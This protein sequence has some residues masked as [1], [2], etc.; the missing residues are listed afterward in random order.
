[1]EKDQYLFNAELSINSLRSGVVPSN[2]ITDLTLGQTKISQEIERRLRFLER[3]ELKSFFVL[4]SYGEGKTHTLEFMKDRV[5][6]NNAANSLLTLHPKEMKLSHQPEIYGTIVSSL[7]LPMSTSSDGLYTLL[8][9]WEKKF[10]KIGA[11]NWKEYVTSLFADCNNQR[12]ILD[13]AVYPL[14]KDPSE[15]EF[16]YRDLLGEK[17]DANRLK[18]I[19]RSTIFNSSIPKSLVVD[20]EEYLHVIKIITRVLLEVG[21]KGL[22][23]LFDEV[24]SIHDLMKNQRKKVYENMVRFIRISPEHFGKVLVI[25]AVTPSFFHSI[26]K[27]YSVSTFEIRETIL[28]LDQ[29][30]LTFTSSADELIS[31]LKNIMDAHGVTYYWDPES[32]LSQNH[33]HRFAKKRLGEELRSVIRYFIEILDY[34]YLYSEDRLL[35]DIWIEE[36]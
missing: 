3:G 35:L 22:V 6:K 8:H 20:K 17:V 32:I 10:K 31:F 7:Q 2:G 19:F 16:L 34:L 27:D 24:E 18:R 13:F 30:P 28:E 21:I 26:E 5:Q 23:L 33:L 9:L 1:M 11:V 36:G 15:K 14:L 12:F 4:G 25:F 29:Y